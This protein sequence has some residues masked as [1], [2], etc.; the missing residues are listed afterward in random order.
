M[1]E[2][3]VRWDLSLPL[4]ALMHQSCW[5]QIDSVDRSRS[6]G[7]ETEWLLLTL[8][9]EKWAVRGKQRSENYIHMI[10]HVYHLHELEALLIQYHQKRNLYNH[11]NIIYIHTNIPQHPSMGG[12]RLRLSFVFFLAG[13]L[14]NLRGSVFRRN[15]WARSG[16][17]VRRKLPV[18]WWSA[19]WAA[20]FS[21]TEE[22][23]L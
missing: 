5:A 23:R 12:H 7:S 13:T 20:V 21:F 2:A 8:G 18:T 3:P 16:R 4:D 22:R 10:L 1:W 19:H 11:Y 9:Y 14:R 17:T 15:R 6:W